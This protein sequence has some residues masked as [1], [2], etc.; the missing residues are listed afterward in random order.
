MTDTTD[1]TGKRDA[2]ETRTAQARAIEHGTIL[3]SGKGWVSGVYVEQDRAAREILTAEYGSERALGYS[4]EYGWDVSDDEAVM[5]ELRA[6][7]DEIERD[8]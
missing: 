1:T 2:D 6:W 8:G 4:E 7:R 5:A 3:D